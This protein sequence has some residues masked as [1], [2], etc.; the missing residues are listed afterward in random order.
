MQ[1]KLS[2]EKIRNI[3]EKASLFIRTKRLQA[4]E[5]LL[6]ETLSKEPNAS[7][8]NLL[9]AKLYQVQSNY[10]KAIEQLSKALSSNPNFLEASITLCGILCDLGQYEEAQEQYQKIY[11]E[12]VNKGSLPQ[13]VRGRIANLHAESGKTYEKTGLINEAASEYIK[14]L[15]LYREMPDIR[16]KLA[17]ILLNQGHI[18]KAKRELSIL[19]EKSPTNPEALAVLGVALYKENL[20]DDARDQW[21]RALQ[22]DP[23]NPLAKSY[24]LLIDPS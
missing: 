8:I 19:M 14:A 9:L 2:R 23:N 3:E 24:T 12:K 1:E 5:N 18:N 7:N 16:L 10:P 20:I 15:N 4:A 13:T 6:I 21:K 11:K 17:K 22:I